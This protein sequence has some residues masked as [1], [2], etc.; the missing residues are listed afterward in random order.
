MQQVIK[1][2]EIAKISAKK[3][4]RLRLVKRLSHPQGQPLRPRSSSPRA[5]AV[6]GAGRREVPERGWGGGGSV[7]QNIL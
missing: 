6:G 1:I 2:A 3:T 5:L 7:I 4:Y